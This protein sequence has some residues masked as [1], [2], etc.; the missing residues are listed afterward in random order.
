MYRVT[1]YRNVSTCFFFI[2]T[3]RHFTSAVHMYVLMVQH[4]TRPQMREQPVNNNSLSTMNAIMPKCYIM[5]MSP[6]SLGNCTIYSTWCIMICLVIPI[7]SLLLFIQSLYSLSKLQ[8]FYLL[9]SC[10][11]F[12]AFSNYYTAVIRPN[13]NTLI[14]LQQLVIFRRERVNET[15]VVH[16]TSQEQNLL[17][18]CVCL[19]P[20]AATYVHVHVHSYVL[21]YG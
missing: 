9:V 21:R 7:L 19:L 2:V 20:P 5:C 3:S 18:H 1:G 11:F 4:E 8:I 14:P 6:S 15:V 10:P 12:A 17:F 13:P 16:Y